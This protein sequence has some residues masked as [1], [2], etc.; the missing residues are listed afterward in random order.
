MK[1]LCGLLMLVALGSSAHAGQSISFSVAGHR[2]H[3]AAPPNC[4]S[5]SCASV[6][7]SG[8]YG[9]RLRRDRED[10]RDPSTPLAAPAQISA[11]PTPPLPAK[12]VIAVVPPPRPAPPAS[13]VGFDTAASVT[14][15]AAL[16][17]L[18]PVPAPPQLQPANPVSQPCVAPS[19]EKPLE[20]LPQ[21]SAPAGPPQAVNAL[22]EQEAA[23]TPVG[24]WQTEAK[25]AVRIVRCGAALCGHAIHA[26]SSDKG[27]TVLIN[28]KPK[29]D[30]RWAGRVYSKDSG[31]T[32]Y[33]TVDL[34]SPN[35]LRVEAC[36]FGRFYCTG[37]NWTRISGN[38]ERLIT[39]RQISP[40][41]RS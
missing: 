28:M 14:K 21:P 31:D 41:P 2:I 10:D 23:D 5:A 26:S 34:K 1:R 39:S 24:D 4:R 22:H 27:E 25:G 6:S 37:N 18:P 7:V 20:I 17:P 38:A 30:S 33:G 13:T 8:I 35:T 40:E 19:A 29:S 11:P 3:I 15:P 36:A 9:S 32:Y 12:P 16:P